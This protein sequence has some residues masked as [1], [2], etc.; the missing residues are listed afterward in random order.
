MSIAIQP[1]AEEKPVSFDDMP[2]QN[3]V[4]VSSNKNRAAPPRKRRPPAR[5]KNGETNGIDS[6]E[7]IAQT[8]E[9]VCF[10][11]QHKKL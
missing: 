11:F 5:H 2:S 8:N 4:I 10:Y 1:D 6:C 3:H 7:E 9:K